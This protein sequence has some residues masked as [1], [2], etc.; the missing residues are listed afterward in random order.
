[1][2][3]LYPVDAK[4]SMKHTMARVLRTLRD[5]RRTLLHVLSMFAKDPVLAK[6]EEALQCIHVGCDKEENTL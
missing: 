6:K 1:M 2:G 3:A 5:H 4:G